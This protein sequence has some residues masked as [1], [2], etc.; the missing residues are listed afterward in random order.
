MVL[1]IDYDFGFRVTGRS[2]LW[3]LPVNG[4]QLSM[5]CSP[6]LAQIP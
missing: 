4:I 3:P 6:H 1:S 5:V 2:R